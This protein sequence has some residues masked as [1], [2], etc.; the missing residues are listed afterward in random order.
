MTI[1]SMASLLRPTVALGEMRA[2]P[3]AAMEASAIRQSA[4]A[5]FLNN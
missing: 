2:S 5:N 4:F 1:R 3:S